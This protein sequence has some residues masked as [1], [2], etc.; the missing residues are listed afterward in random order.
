MLLKMVTPPGSRVMDLTHLVE[1]VH[2]QPGVV[3]PLRLRS[4]RP[5]FRNPET[6]N[7]R[8]GNDVGG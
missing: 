1:A 6:A 5:A 3:D 7:A 8:R 4:Q 2:N